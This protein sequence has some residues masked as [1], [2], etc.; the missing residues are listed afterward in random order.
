M[1]PF[2]FLIP[3]A[4]VLVLAGCNNNTSTGKMTPRIPVYDSHGFPGHEHAAHKQEI[5]DHQVF[6]KDGW[7]QPWMNYDTLLVWS[8]NFIIDGPQFEMPEGRLPG[9]IVT[10]SY[11]TYRAAYP[12]VLTED[13][14]YH[15]RRVV[16][17]QGSNAYFAMKLFRYYY[18]YTGDIRALVPV[19]DFLDRML[20]FPTP[21]DWAWPGM[22]RTQDNDDPDGIYLDER[23]E[24]DKAAMVGV[25]YM[26]FATFTGEEK[27]QAMADHIAEL[28]I[29]NIKEGSERESPLPFRVNMR[30]GEA[31]DAYTSDMIFV[32]EFFDKILAADTSLDKALVKAKRDL[33]FNWVME[34][35]VKNG[36]WSGYFEDIDSESLS[37]MNQFAPMETARYL[38][39]N[40]ETCKEYKQ[41]VLDLLAFV[42]GRFG[43]TV[44]YG[45]VSICEQDVCFFEMSSHAAR[46]GSVLAR[47]AA[48]TRCEQAKKE[49]LATLALAE[50]S[51]CNHT[52]KGNI[53]VNSVGIEWYGI[54][55]SDSYF[56]YLPHYLEGM[57]A[58]P[59]IIPEGTD[60]IFS[61]TCMLKDVEYA[62]GSVKYT[63]L[64]PNGTERLKLS[65]EPKVLS[66]GK[67]LPKSC[68]KVG[69]YRGCDNILTI[70]RK[71][72]TDIEIVKK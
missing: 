25:A 15:D 2:R 49:A 71:D 64:E 62:P 29:K 42:K 39:N 48:E 41:V 33:I 28:L 53:S 56:D 17:N 50:Y 22:V 12:D 40:P 4:C 72:V 61:T 52:S 5:L 32:V 13:G 19:K 6:V 36:L 35:P 54:W 59:E 30:T 34:Y 67:P 3:I 24:T 23:I 68:W 31:E 58:W 9:Y 26:D 44:R 60:H 63:A 57:A 70:N 65:F 8:M 38:L 47:W 10:S 21:D 55:Y 18:P 69:K 46:Y 51:A 14:L 43:G 66:G 11:G 16:N 27:Y 7:L 37:N 20:M 1:R 45:G